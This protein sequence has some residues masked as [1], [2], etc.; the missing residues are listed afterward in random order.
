MSAIGRAS[1]KPRGT[2]RPSAQLKS[3]PAMRPL[4]RD[5]PVEKTVVAPVLRVFPRRSLNPGRRLTVYVVFGFQPCRGCTAISLRCQSACVSP[6][7]GEMRKSALSV[8]A[9]DGL[10][11]TTSSNWNMI[12]RGVTP[13]LPLSGAMR[14]IFG[15]SVSTGPPGGVPGEA[16]AT[17]LPAIALS[18]M[19]LRI[20]KA[21]PLSALAA[22]AAL[23]NRPASAARPQRHSPGRD[24]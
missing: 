16:H 19:A 6:L 18:A 14:T 21:T 22:L 4:A 10:S 3:V 9:P 11:F 17:A 2:V 1:I 8:G 15:A 12:S 20:R 24:R 5:A 13:V 7:R 23:T